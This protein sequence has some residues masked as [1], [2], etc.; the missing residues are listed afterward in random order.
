MRI[1]QPVRALKTSR[2]ARFYMLMSWWYV[3]ANLCISVFSSFLERKN[4][5]SPLNVSACTDAHQPVYLMSFRFGCEQRWEQHGPCRPF[6]SSVLTQSFHLSGSPSAFLSLSL[7]CTHAH[8][9]NA[10]MC[11]NTCTEIFNMDKWYLVEEFNLPLSIPP[12]SLSLSGCHRTCQALMPSNLFSNTHCRLSFKSLLE[13]MSSISTPP[14][15]HSLSR[16]VGLTTR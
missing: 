1:F 4:S 9:R 14:T 6:S 11:M 3:R 2:L 12:P 16:L 15:L 7:S 10:Y 13:G 8:W 5:A